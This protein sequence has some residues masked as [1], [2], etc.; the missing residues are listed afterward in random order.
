LAHAYGPSL[1]RSLFL[2]LSALSLTTLSASAQQT[3]TAPETSSAAL[4]DAPSYISAASAESSSLSDNNTQTTAP[5]PA[6][7]HTTQTIEAPRFHMRIGPDETAQ[8]LTVMETVGL[9]LKDSVSLF[10]MSGWITTAGWS[11]AFNTTPNYGTDSGAFGQRLGAATVRG[12]S[13]GIFGNSVFAPMFH[14][15]PR[16]YR[17]GRGP[18]KERLWYAAKRVVI[19]R[20]STDGRPVPN[21]SV[22]AGNAASSA[23]T[24]AYYPPRD[25][26]AFQVSKTYGESFIGSLVGCMSSEFLP[27]V[28]AFIHIKMPPQ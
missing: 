2:L 16:Y 11:H 15:D 9:G 1:F 10:S 26:T 23:M 13:K 27:D 18:F 8:K 3:G 24:V 19:T 25:T 12:I 14:E 6:P 7:V 4:P 21:F 20:S 17:M 5:D 28:F 22:F